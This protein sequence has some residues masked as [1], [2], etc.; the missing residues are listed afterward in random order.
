MCE[1]I[2]DMCASQIEKKQLISLIL[3]EE[4]IPDRKSTLQLALS[5][6]RSHLGLNGETPSRGTL[7]D[8]QYQRYETSLGTN[9]SEEADLFSGLLIYLICL[10]QIGVIFC[11]GKD[12]IDAA[13]NTFYGD[14]INLD[15][16]QVEAIRNLRNALA[17]SFG[18]INICQNLPRNKFLISFDENP[19]KMVELPQSTYSRFDDKEDKSET[20]IYAFSVISM[21][22]QIMSELVKRFR[23]GVLEMK[24]DFEMVLARYTIKI[25]Y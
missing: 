6:A 22:E 14:A 16:K 24:A 9:V 21:V 15:K 2:Q 23:A 18:L 17:H 3:G 12:K 1:L 11:E 20:V 5:A 13:I 19:K 7:T 25:K 4:T 8:L 10:E